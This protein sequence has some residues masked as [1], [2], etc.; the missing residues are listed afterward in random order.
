[1]PSDES[2]IK[3]DWQPYPI[4]FT[5]KVEHIKG[6]EGKKV[7]DKEDKSFEDVLRE[8]LDKGLDKG[9]KKKKGKHWLDKAIDVYAGNKLGVNVDIYI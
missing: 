4:D 5:G 6:V 9:I 2:K 1:M 3:H 8:V 7:K